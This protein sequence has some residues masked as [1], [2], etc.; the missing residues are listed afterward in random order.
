MK[1]NKV[2][3]LGG[4]IASCLWLSACA[5]LPPQT[6]KI[7]GHTSQS[8]LDWAGG[9]FG[10]MPAVGTQPERA[11]ALWLA[12]NNAYRLDLG[13]WGS[14]GMQSLTGKVSWQAGRV[15]ELIGA[16]SALSHWQVREGSLRGGANNALTLQQAAPLVGAL[17]LPEAWVLQSL[18]G[19]SRP[20]GAKPPELSFSMAGRV[21]GFDGC[22]RLMGGFT[23][24]PPNGFALKQLAGTLM[25]C[26]QPDNPD[27]AFRAMLE[28]V[29]AAEIQGETL[30]LSNAQGHV[31][32]ELRAVS[33]QAL[34]S[35]SR[36]NSASRPE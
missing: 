19:A 20:Y 4:V 11:M 3:A 1:K 32:A 9:Y 24:N 22:N 34:P 10:Q 18:P 25:A 7:D 5:P 17:A 29:A 27:R 35:S 36:K 23:L 15:I 2:W 21:A 12:P 33:S 14:R 8:A 16:P 31:I 26:V 28:H 30:I 13:D 6:A